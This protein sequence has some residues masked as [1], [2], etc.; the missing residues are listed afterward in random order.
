MVCRE[1]TLFRGVW[2]LHPLISHTEALPGIT[3]LSS[4]VHIVLSH[5]DDACVWVIR[6]VLTET[7]TS[8]LCT[9]TS[10]RDRTSSLRNVLRTSRC[11]L[12]THTTITASLTTAATIS[13]CQPNPPSGYSTDVKKTFT[14]NL[15]RLKRK[16]IE[17]VCERWIIN[18]T[19]NSLW[20]LSEKMGTFLFSIS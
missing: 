18:V 8:G 6:V 9:T 10:S 3:F 16:K 4:H 14:N 7:S 5:R 13:P 2:P 17:N 11:H 1:P 19:N 20:L 12:A 15:K